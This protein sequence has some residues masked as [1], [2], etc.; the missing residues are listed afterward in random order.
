M[1]TTVTVQVNQYLLISILCVGIV[2]LFKK[3]LLKYK[4]EIL[5]GTAILSAVIGLFALI[6]HAAKDIKKQQ[7][8]FT[9]QKQ[10]LIEQ[11]LPSE[12]TPIVNLFTSNVLTNS[13]KGLVINQHL[14]PPTA[15]LTP[16]QFQTLV[17]LIRKSGGTQSEDVLV[18]PLVPYIDF[19]KQNP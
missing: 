15:K 4:L 16:T 18:N 14:P 7:E 17:N 8:C 3:P 11:S 9:A 6:A 12:W 19:S 13:G 2:I 1:P 5:A 10:Q